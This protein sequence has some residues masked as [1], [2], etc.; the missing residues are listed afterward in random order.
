MAKVVCIIRIHQ[1]GAC[2]TKTEYI[3]VIGRK[4]AGEKM[5]ELLESEK[6]NGA[7]TSPVNY[8]DW[9]RYRNFHRLSIESFHSSHPSRVEKSFTLYVG[10][11]GKAISS[12][13][14]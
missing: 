14:A 11:S 10:E 7:Y 9:G 2:E 1:Y 12:D 3:P 8:A 4:S 6:A 13:Q 5:Y